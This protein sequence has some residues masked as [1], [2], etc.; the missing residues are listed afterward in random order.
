MS[1]ILI[2]IVL[3]IK[4]AIRFAAGVLNNL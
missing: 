1:M 3:M 2:E 4:D